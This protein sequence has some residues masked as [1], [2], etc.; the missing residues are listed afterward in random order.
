MAIVGVLVLGFVLFFTWLNYSSPVN[1]A[2]REYKKTVKSYRNVE[3]ETMDDVFER[4]QVLER[5][6]N[7]T[8]FDKVQG[9][10]KREVTR[11][12]IET[13][14]GKPDQVVEDVDMNRVDTVY[15]Y[16]YDELTLNFHQ[17]HRTIDEYVMEN[18]SE[19]LY[20]AQTLDRLFIDT[21]INHQT[22]YTKENEQYEPLTEESVPPLISNK[23]STRKI[24]QNGWNTWSFNR[25]YYFDDGLGDYSPTEYLALQFKE[26]HDD[27]D[28]LQLMIR[29][30]NEAYLEKDTID[31]IEKKREALFTFSDVFEQKEMNNLDEEFMVGDFSNEFGE[32]ARMYY[33]FQEGLLGVAFLIKENDYTEEITVKVPVTDVSDISDIDDLAGLEIVEFDSQ[34]FYSSDKALNNTSFIGSK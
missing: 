22:Q 31:E 8:T 25:Q 9:G 12:D 15:Q 17:Y 10:E 34:I 16:H 33:D 24:R 3:I 27:V 30:Y 21:I 7:S 19:T 11:T 32:I 23:T 4:L 20:D 5:H 2:G 29:R 26:D 1:E 14:F 28:K 6:F 18:F 13:L